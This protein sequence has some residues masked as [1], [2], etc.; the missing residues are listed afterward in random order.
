MDNFYAWSNSSTAPDGGSFTSFLGTLNNG[1]STDGGATTAITGCFA[2]PCDWRLPSIVEL[3]GIVGL[4]AS[5]CSSESPCIDPT[6]GPTQAS[7]YWSASTYADDPEGAWGVT[8]FHSFVDSEFKTG[9]NF[10]H[11]VRSG[12]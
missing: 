1:T 3:E 12:L 4:N 7:F 2:N 11:A 6:F 9:F 5:G 10:V 8:F